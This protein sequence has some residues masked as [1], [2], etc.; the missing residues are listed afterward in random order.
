M[1]KRDR[2]YAYNV[3]MMPVRE[4]IVAL[5]KQLNIKPTHSECVFIALDIQ[6]ARRMRHMVMFGLSAFTTF[7]PHYLTTGTIFEKKKK[8]LNLKCVLISYTAFV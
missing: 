2:Q 5:E 8:L 6:H 7:F 3:T 4:T 1:L